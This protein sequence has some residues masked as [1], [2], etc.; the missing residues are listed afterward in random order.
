MTRFVSSI[1][2]VAGLAAQA[3][4]EA[5]GNAQFGRLIAGAAPAQVVFLN[6]PECGVLRARIGQS[7]APPYV[8]MLYMC[9]TGHI[10][11]AEHIAD[12]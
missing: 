9:S 6:N 10:D 1:V 5:L 3:H 2:L 7:A 12:T 11:L 4:S 8:S